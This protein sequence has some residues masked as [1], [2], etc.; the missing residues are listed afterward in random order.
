VVDDEVKSEW[1]PFRTSIMTSMCSS[2]HLIHRLLRTVGEGADGDKAATAR[3]L[4]LL[5]SGGS[6]YPV[7]ELKA[8]GVDMTTSE[9]LQLTMKKM[10]RLMDE[11]EKSWTNR[12]SRRQRTRLIEQA[13]AG[14]GKGPSQAT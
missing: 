14:G 11:A 7:A 13:R 12:R 9:P 8:A 6:D 10:N 5:K 1:R 4:N 2:T 3:Y